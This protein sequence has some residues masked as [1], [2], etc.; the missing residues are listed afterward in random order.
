[1]RTQERGGL[2]AVLAALTTAGMLY[3]CGSDNPSGESATAPIATQPQPQP[4]PLGDAASASA[5]I[6]SAWVVLGED[7]QA[8]ARAITSYSAPLPASGS[9]D[10]NASCPLLT[11]DGKASRMTLRVAAG[12]V[13]LRTTAS[14]PADSKPSSFPVNV[15]EAKLPA[16]AATASVAGQKLPLPKAEPQRI[17]VLADTG[18]RLKK[19]D[20]AYQPCSDGT[21]WPFAA[22]ATTAAGFNPDLVLH[23]GDYHYRENACPD[24]IA[25]CKGSPWG[26]GWDTWQA[27]LFKPAAPLL[28]KAPW[29]MVRGNHEECARAGQGWYRFLD[30]R[31]Y[32]SATS[33]DNPADDNTANYSE[34]YAVTLGSESQVI[35]FDTAKVGKAALKTTDAQFQVYR[36]Q[37]QSVAAMAGK[38]GMSTTIFTNHHPILAFAPVAGANPAPG[39][40]AMQSVMTDLN[41]TAYYPTGVQVALH[42]HVHDFQAIN[43]ASTHPATIVSGNGG[44]NLDVALPDPLPAGILPAPGTTLDKITHHSSFGFMLMERR[45]SPAKGWLFKSYTVAGKLLTTCTQTGS[46]LACDKSGF[47]AP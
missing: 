31:P 36:K 14:A 37:L 41:G 32:A 7:N 43:F 2:L 44:D 13:P 27:D 10:P 42:G 46:S 47:V 39:N 3:G 16:G 40:L 23:I 34:P 20:N 35:V 30:T 22:L 6:Q 33:C 19:A 17:L 11:V 8:I 25:G 24:D 21:A 38:T 26:Y 45:A 9:A 15:C 5:N 12:T 1:M 29:I 18:C 4:Q 28:A